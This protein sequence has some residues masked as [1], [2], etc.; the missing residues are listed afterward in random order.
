[1]HI[2]RGEP[3]SPSSEQHV[4]DMHC[5]T[6]IFVVGQCPQNCLLRP[7]ASIEIM[8]PSIEPPPT[9]RALLTPPPPPQGCIGRGRGTPPPASPQGAQP[10]PS[11]C[12][13]HAKWR[14]QWHL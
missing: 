12:L 14:L 1:M 4:M 6:D 10:M 11:H 9:P 8:V 5:I 2:P 7:S 13:P 3:C